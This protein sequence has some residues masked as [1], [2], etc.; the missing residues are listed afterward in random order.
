MRTLFQTINAAYDDYEIEYRLHATRRIF[1][2]NILEYDVEA[3][4]RKGIIIEHYDEDLPFPSFLINGIAPT[5][6]IPLHIVVALN[7]KERKLV[8]ITVYRP[9]QKKWTNQFS[10]RIK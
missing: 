4:L 1:Q 8:V 10:R 5:G 3:V 7:E 6:G 9:D 2:R